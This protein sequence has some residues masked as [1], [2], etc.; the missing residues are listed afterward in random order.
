MEQRRRRFG[1]WLTAVGV[2]V[3]SAAVASPSPVYPLYQAEWHLSAAAMTGMFAIY[4]AGLLGGLL[5]AGSLSDFVGRRAVALP[6]LVICFLALILLGSADGL[7]MV[8]VARTVQGIAMSLVVG[9]LGASLL[10]FA[11]PANPR[12]AATFNG[13]LWPFGLAVGALL[14]GVLV[15]DAPAPTHLVFYILAAVVAVIFVAMFRLP[16]TRPRQPGALASLVPTVGLPPRVR[17]IFFAVLGCLL[18]AWALG[19]LYLGMGASIVGSLFGIHAALDAALAMAAVTGVGALTGIATQRR[20]A[21]R[22]ML[23]GA[24]TLIVGPLLTVV[25]VHAQ[26]SWLFYLSSVVSGV[27]FGAGFQG[28]LRL[29]LAEADEDGRAGVLSVIYVACYG[30]FSI[31]ALVAGILTPHLGL[32]EVVT[33]Y[34]VLVVVMAAIALGLQ[35]TR[36]S[37]REPE[38]VADADEQARQHERQYEP[39]H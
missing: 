10:D 7:A 38:L 31:P 27:G 25:A 9:S 13:A 6:A 37:I 11:P 39:T 22:V 36:R 19:G 1:F 14:G 24:A 34:A 26:A 28:G 15:D 2:L 33:G 5:T 30:A 17:G 16:D 3:F 4:V 21:R 8:L 20:D 23:V 12:I 18:A 29:I 35:L 32:S